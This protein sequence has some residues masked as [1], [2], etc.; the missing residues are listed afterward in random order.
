LNF[1]A[2]GVE[3]V[4][5]IPQSL[6]AF[7]IPSLGLA[8]KLWPGALAIALMSFTETIA[9]GRAF[10]NDDE[11]SPQANRELLATGLANI[12]GALFGAMPGGG[13]TSQTAVNHLQR[14]NGGRRGSSSSLFC[15]L[16]WHACQ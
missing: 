13:G 3:L 11:Q 4:G 8:E 6:P 16:G 1:Y 7:T 12:G 9:A 15:L 14:R 5:R 10:T 2:R